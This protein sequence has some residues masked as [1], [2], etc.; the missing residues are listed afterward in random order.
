MSKYIRG[1]KKTLNTPQLPK[2]PPKDLYRSPIHAV[3]RG[4]ISPAAVGLASMMLMSTAAAQDA[5][6]PP[7]QDSGGVT[8]QQS[9]TPQQPAATPA[10]PSTPTQ[11]PPAASSQPPSTTALPEIQVRSARRPVRP[12]PQ[13]TAPAPAAPPPPVEQNPYGDVGYQ[14]NQ[15]SI[16]RLP[17]PLRDTPQT[18]NVVTQQLIQDQRSVS[19]E[20]ALRYVPGITFSAGEGGQQGDGPII[21]GFAPHKRLHDF[22]RVPRDHQTVRS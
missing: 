19:M 5:G 10:Q 6:T 17:T 15:Q 1:S 16:T 14:G 21:R 18:V 4:P 8:Q 7:R 11:T 3:V 2:Y 20:D 13:P 9:V 22:P 12:A